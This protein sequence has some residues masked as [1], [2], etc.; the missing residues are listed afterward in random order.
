M[1]PKIAISDL[2]DE[3]PDGPGFFR[4][5][6]GKDESAVFLSWWKQSSPD[7]M[8]PDGTYRSPQ[9]RCQI[10]TCTSDGEQSINSPSFL[11]LHGIKLL[12]A[13]EVQNEGYRL[14]LI[15]RFIEAQIKKSRLPIDQRAVVLGPMIV[16]L[17]TW[18]RE[19]RTRVSAIPH[20]VTFADPEYSAEASKEMPDFYGPPYWFGDISFELEDVFAKTLENIGGFGGKLARK[21]REKNETIRQNMP[22]FA[23]E[24]E[25]WEFWSPWLPGLD[26]RAP[27]RHQDII[28]AI[29]NDLVLPQLERSQK[30]PPALAR[31][32]Y[33]PVVEILSAPPILVEETTGQRT[34][35]LGIPQTCVIR[36]DAAAAPYVD[37]G[38]ELFQSIHAHK[39]LRHLSFESHKKALDGATDPR[40]LTYEGGYSALAEACGIH[41][42][43]GAK[44]VRVLIETLR[45]LD[46]SA[47]PGQVAGL[48]TRT[49][50]EARGQRRAFLKIIV[51]T[52]LLP[53][54][55]YELQRVAGTT[56]V[57]ARRDQDLIPLLDIPPTIGRPNDAGPQATLSLRV[58]A[59]MRDHATDLAQG[60]GA[61]LPL[62]TFC[63]LAAASNVSRSLAPRV[64]DHWLQDHEDGPALLKRLERDRFTLGDKHAAA[65]AFI[66]A[67]GQKSL[68]ASEAGRRSVTKRNAAQRKMRGQK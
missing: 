52:P 27:E 4:L 29:W 51:G 50:A 65:R 33:G 8:Q 58:V 67:G 46:I 24:K 42:A 30:K 11:G 10:T 15:N 19:L 22:D 68:D 36:V 44:K 37:K 38:I 7:P 43:D 31:V 32:V 45:L 20:R 48:F 56:S 5:R 47:L 54:Y 57:A 28:L 61:P 40:A 62:E 63:D 13:Q 1:I 55:V 53:D 64:L 9:D 2:P 25:V 14:S 39:I 59:H 12:G 41:G 16:W 23:G 60:R 34:L 18:G 26:G 6:F 17:E 3:Q 35:D 66:E 21:I 49:F